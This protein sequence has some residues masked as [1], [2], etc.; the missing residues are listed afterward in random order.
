MEEKRNT[1]KGYAL[2]NINTE[3]FAVKRSLKLLK[4]L[5]EY[6]NDKRFFDNI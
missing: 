4:T 3:S 6:P 1:L 2:V 5:G